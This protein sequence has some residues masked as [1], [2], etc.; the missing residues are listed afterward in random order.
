MQRIKISCGFSLLFTDINFFFLF[1]SLVG[2]IIAILRGFA[3][4]NT[5]EKAFESK[6]L[7]IPRAPGLGLVLESVSYIPFYCYFNI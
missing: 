6:K 2:I 5:L 7:D 1:F 4:K 3:S